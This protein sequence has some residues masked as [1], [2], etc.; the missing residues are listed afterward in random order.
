MKLW[1][2]L[3]FC[4]DIFL[5]SVKIALI[6]GTLLMLINYGDV[7]WVRGFLLPDEIIRVLLTYIVPYCV[8]TWTSVAAYKRHHPELKGEQGAMVGKEAFLTLLEGVCLKQ[9]QSSCLIFAEIN[10]A[11]QVACFLQGFVTEKQ[12][13]EQIEQCIS[14]QVAQYPQAIFAKLEHNRFGIILPENT[15]QSLIIAE[16]LAYSLDTKIILVEDI[17]YYP[18]LYIGVTP[19]TPDYS[20]AKL[21]FA[22]ADI[23]LHEARKTGGSVV[24]L[25]EPDSPKI[26]RYRRA[27]QLLPKIRAGL[28]N[29]SFVLFTQPI[30]SINSASESKKEEVLL[31]YQDSK[32]DFHEPSPY[33]SAAELFHVSREI[34]LY[35]VHQFCLFMQH[36]KDEMTVYSL[37]ISGNTVRYHLFFD[38]VAEQ[39]KRYKIDTRR[40]CF[41]MTENVADQDME[42]ATLLMRRLKQEL[43]CQLSLDDIGI[44]SSNLETMPKFNVDYMK[45]DGSYVRDFLDNQYAEL[46]IRFITEAAQLEGK[47]TVAEYVE[48]PEQLEKLRAIGVDY[49]Q[50]YLLG[51]PT[52]LFDPAR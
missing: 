36:N 22:A 47:Q 2:S 37:N 33:F 9:Q 17:S 14:E 42:D 10:N 52:L 15:A 27:L 19:I 5:Y 16:Q 43:G 7:L 11:T 30:V 13:I 1:F 8:S 38:Y 29:K 32:G 35:V 23:A 3:A 34:D 50:G 4:K 41:E 18:K 31:R 46:V 44:G 40:V 21:A 51:K 12:L 45:I 26:V 6:V 20:E 48:T 39:F 24:K 25:L 49:G 28:L